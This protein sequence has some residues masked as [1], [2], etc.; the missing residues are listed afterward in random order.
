MAISPESLFQKKSQTEHMS[1]LS[2]LT[3]ELMKDP[4]FSHEYE[5]LQPEMD[6]I[7]AFL[8]AEINSEKTVC[9]G[10]VH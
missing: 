9:S 7:R 6:N 5:S 2:K 8:D 10:V 1:D 4:E 3:D